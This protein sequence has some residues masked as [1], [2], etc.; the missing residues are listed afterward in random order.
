MTDGTDNW[1]RNTGLL[2]GIM[3]CQ[4]SQIWQILKAVKF[5]LS[6]LAF[7]WHFT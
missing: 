4:M 7:F 2:N 3:W 5:G 6:S 1:S